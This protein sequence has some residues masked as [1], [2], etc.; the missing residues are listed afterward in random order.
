MEGRI[1][2]ARVNGDE[3]DICIIPE[4][5]KAVRHHIEY[6]GE[7]DELIGKSCSYEL[8]N[9]RVTDFI[10]GAS[11]VTAPQG[12][13]GG[14]VGKNFRPGPAQK[15]ASGPASKPPPR[16]EK[17]SQSL[18]T[19]RLATRGRSPYNFVPL[20][21]QVVYPPV[22]VPDYDRYHSDLISGHIDLTIETLTPLYI[23]DSYTPEEEIKYNQSREKSKEK[24][25]HGQARDDS[26]EKWENSDFFSPG[27]AP[28]IPGSSL[29]GLIRTLVE[30]ISWSRMDSVSNAILYFR[31]VAGKSASFRNAYLDRMTV[32]DASGNTLGYKARA[33][34]ITGSGR[35]YWIIPAREENGRQFSRPEIRSSDKPF[36][37]SWQGEKCLVVPGP[38]PVKEGVKHNW[39][40]NAPDTNTPTVPISDEDLKA[41]KKD[42][43]RKTEADVL[44]R[45][46][47]EQTARG[48]VPCFYTI[49]K[50]S[51]GGQRVAFGHTGYFRLPYLFSVHDHM[52]ASHRKHSQEKPDTAQMLFGE[53]G[54]RAGKLFFEDA[55][56]ETGQSGV[57]LQ[58]SSPRILSGPKPTTFQHYLEQSRTDINTLEHW[59]V[60]DTRIRGYK[61]YWHRQTPTDSRKP[62]SWN[63]GRVIKDSQHTVIRPVRPGAVFAGR[64]RFE[65]LSAFELGALLSALELPEGCRHKLGM[66]KPLGLGSV[67]IRPHLYLDDR[68][69]R[70]RSL[71][72]G[73]G[74]WQERCQEAD[75]TQ[76]RD[77]FAAEM[78]YQ[79]DTQLQGQEGA[80]KTEKPAVTG[81]AVRLWK[82]PRLAEL[83]AML[84]YPGTES[85]TW[86]EETRYLEITRKNPSGGKSINEFADRGVLPA[87]RQVLKQG[88]RDQA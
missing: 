63:E 36:S 4:G 66:G 3:I 2:E 78:L 10:L 51:A 74:N 18:G 43:G 50:D 80:Q 16:Q 38:I 76:Y 17:A 53:A 83:E 44:N 32:R 81:A 56:L 37:I 34:Y 65:N 29:R 52:P 14:M 77:I 9:G 39:L 20:S 82:H 73:Q 88:Q 45:L 7:A 40:I 57:Y 42:N 48:M 19:G 60:R 69:H 1:T 85:P 47:E 31:G 86:L 54:Q 24:S 21:E 61:F 87:P 22:A 55:L 68:S 23:R 64:M 84:K 79:L 46:K 25:K 5:G 71:F 41:Y 67:A 33:G 27:G 72:D 58:E 12:T 49:W 13:R 15:S 8:H 30:V 11:Q 75:G 26:K 70:Y 28:R 59:D 35:R 6:P 62:Y